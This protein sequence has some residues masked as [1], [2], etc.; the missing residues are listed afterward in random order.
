M[1]WRAHRGWVSHAQFLDIGR[2]TDDPA[3]PPMVLTSGGMDGVVALWDVSKAGHVTGDPSRA[4]D[5]AETSE[6]G[7]GVGVFSAHAAA[8]AGGDAIA[9][10]VTGSKDSTVRLWDL[11]R[12]SGFALARTFDARHRG[13]VKCVRWRPSPGGGDGG[14]TASRTTPFAC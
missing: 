12:A 7:A 5:V 13:V 2:N 9:R 4:R 10:V 11:S 6:A 3:A 1:S 14:E 8:R